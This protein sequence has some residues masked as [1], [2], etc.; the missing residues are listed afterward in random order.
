MPANGVGASEVAAQKADRAQNDTASVLEDGVIAIDVL[1]NDGNGN[2]K[3]LYSLNQGNLQ[4]RTLGDLWVTL[5]SGARV[6]FHNGLVEY[7]AA[8]LDHLAAGAALVDT[9][10]YSVKFNNGVI[11]SANVAVTV[12]GSNDGPIAAPE[13]VSGHENQVLAVNVLANDSDVDDGAV[14]TVTA[15]SSLAGKGSVSIVG[16]QVR[17]TPGADFDHLAQG[18]SEQV[19]LSYTIADQHGASSS[20]TVTVTVTGTNDGPLAN[21]D[22]AAGT[23]NQILLINAMTNDTDVDDG[24]VKMLVSASV[25]AGKGTASIFGNQVQFNPGSDFNHLAQGAT[26][27][28]VLSYTIADQHGA[29]STSTVTVT[30]TGTNDG[31]VANPDVAATTENTSVT[32]DALAND[33][34]VDDGAIKTLIAA[35]APANKGAASVVANQVVFN[36]GTNF[37]HLAQGATEIVLLGYTMQD[38]HGTLSSSTISVTVTG[39]NDGPVANG[40]SAVTSEN[41]S[42][43]VNVLGNDTDLDDGAI[44]TVA[45]ASVPA[46]QGS[47]AIIDNRVQFN[48]GSALDYLAIGESADVVVS[49]STQDQHGASASSTVTITV[50]GTNDAPTIDAGSSVSTGS[51]TELTNADPGEGTT[52]HEVNGVIA[53]GDRDLSDTHGATAAALGGGYLGTF[54]L[55]PVNQNSRTVGWN[56]DV[57]DA[58]LDNLEEGEVVTQIYTVAISDGHGG[59]ATQ[60]VTITLTGAAENA[61]PQALADSVATAEDTAVTID[62]LAN[63][64]DA[65]GDALVSEIVSEP[66]HGTLTLDPVTG[67][68]TYQPDPDFHGN[69]LFT[70]RISDPAG[71]QSDI[72]VVSITIAS[73]NDPPLLTQILPNRTGQ[74]LQSVAVS[75]PPNL[76]VDN[77]GSGAILYSAELVGDEPLPGWLSF[78]PVSL[79]LSGTPGNGDAGHYSIRITGAEDDGQKAATSFMLTILDGSTID[80]TNDGETITGTIQGD[81][82]R[83]FGGSDTVNAST[84]ADLVDGGTGNDALYGEFGD[85]IISGGADN[86]FLAGG[87]GADLL[88]GEAGND[89]LDGGQGNDRLEGGDGS[90]ILFGGAGGSDEMIGGAGDDTIFLNTFV[91]EQSGDGGEGDDVFVVIGRVAATTITTGSGSD[92]IYIQNPGF[93][94]PLGV[95]TITDFAPGAGGDVFSLDGRNFDAPG[96]LSIL[97]GW[98]GSANPF[99]TGYLRLVQS[100]SN[101]VLQIDRT[102]EVDGAVWAPVAIFQGADATLFTDANFAP[103]YHPDGS[104][105]TG[106]SITGTETGDTLTGTIG[107]DIIDALGG[108]DRVNA[109]SGSDLVYGGFGIDELYGESG[110]DVLQGGEDRDF[111]FGGDGADLLF[112]E[113][114]DDQLN[115][116]DG[117]DRLEG[118]E[119]ND[120]LGDSG[121]STEMFGG[122]GDDTIFLITFNGV[123]QGDGGEGD[124]VF[125]V[126]GRVAAT[127]ITTG[128]GSDRIYI[129]NPGFDIPLGVI[130]ITDFAPGTDGDVFSLDGRNFDSPGLL[131]ILS[132]WDGSTNPFAAGYFRLVQS[133]SDAVLE[134]DLT[135]PANGA[136][137]T[138][139]AI[140]EDTDTALFAGANFAPGYHPDGSPR[141]ERQSPGPRPQMRSQVRSAPI[142]SMLS[143]APTG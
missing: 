114:G 20:S 25:P 46:G 50:T 91:G 19:V 128:S 141:P 39:M 1:A 138:P 119:G 22:T 116:G 106:A 32:I 67:F 11:S 71:A 125:V 82:I 16:N 117:I 102:G 133:G 72:V 27:Q 14:L 113:A 7:D 40:D 9:F 65:D 3:Q 69:D 111:L 142:P 139:I 53:F 62:I 52:V 94:I 101:A 38:E 85:D 83:A 12:T 57:S 136:A 137:W 61:A 79:T 51:V 110:N 47:V 33:A 24:A 56:F 30:V 131:S 124:D 2:N 87:D 77:D 70:Y 81:L 88:F 89:Q 78:D 66:S 109:G 129:Q 120:F 130:T 28:V 105:P 60:D 54:T 74:V 99:E 96:L 29:T 97:S 49:Y 107:A 134:M 63:D 73:V 64:S 112:G 44:L 15:A 103:G 42:V 34:D 93:D 98:D 118:G 80:G 126:V 17:F 127:T 75:V 132:G 123:Q 59:T 76:V 48:P 8:A 41:A 45:A 36:P 5:P 6:R 21:P 10:S 84:G 95:I 26:E 35:A 92:R 121:G 115:G 140:F 13:A 143:A 90:D 68:Y 4:L 55:D 18:V 58:A 122:A 23:E 108:D 104:P 86:D 37:D 135:G 31:P 43:T 100:G